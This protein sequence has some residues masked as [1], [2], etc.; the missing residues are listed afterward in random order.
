MPNT[1]NIKFNNNSGVDN[2]YAFFVGQPVL[3]PN[4]TNKV[5]Y[6][7]IWISQFIPDGG[8]YDITT[9]DQFYACTSAI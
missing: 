5:M 6:S 8:W 7:N 4:P 2:T 9:T 3:S 1:Y